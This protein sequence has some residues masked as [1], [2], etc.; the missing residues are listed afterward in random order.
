[1]SGLVGVNTHGVMALL[2]SFGDTGLGGLG[3]S[4]LG[5]G[6]LTALSGGPKGGGLDVGETLKL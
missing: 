2:L 5:A 1:M 6:G 4:A 3:G